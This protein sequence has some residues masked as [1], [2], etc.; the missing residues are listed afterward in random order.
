[1][2]DLFSLLKGKEESTLVSSQS[3]FDIKE[4]VAY[5]QDHFVGSEMVQCFVMSLVA[6]V[7]G[8]PLIVKGPAGENKTG[9]I[10]DYATNIFDLDFRVAQFTETTPSDVVTGTVNL[11]AMDEG[12]WKH[13]LENGL[14]G[15]D[16]VLLD[17]V[18]KS[19]DRTQHALLSWLNEGGVYDGGKFHKSPTQ[20][21]LATRNYDIDDQAFSDRWNICMYVSRNAG[22]TKFGFLQEFCNLPKKKKFKLDTGVIEDL[23]SKTDKVLNRLKK[24][25]AKG[26]SKF[27]DDLKTF[28]ESVSIEISSRTLVNSLKIMSA[29]AVVHGRNKV[30]TIDLW[31]LQYLFIE[32]DESLIVKQ[33]LEQTFN[34]ISEEGIPYPTVDATM[35]EAKEIAS[36]IERNL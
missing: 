24:D 34:F 29:N 35:Q 30:S 18:E 2:S 21:I 9:F 5:V 1:M 19:A 3:N 12:E 27:C 17:E 31:V 32:E 8:K 26:T 15:G 13:H 33:Q 22:K 23:K 6:H 25:I 11:K 7:S 4:Y 36:N 14:V 16:I 20:L 10:Q 28:L